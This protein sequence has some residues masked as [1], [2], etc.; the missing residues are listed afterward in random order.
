[1]EELR[2]Q[3]RV[4]LQKVEGKQNLSDLL[5]KLLRPSTFNSIIRRIQGTKK[6]KGQMSSRS[7][8]VQTVGG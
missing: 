1:M 6:S 8:M 2:D 5:T 3:G 7:S 4:N